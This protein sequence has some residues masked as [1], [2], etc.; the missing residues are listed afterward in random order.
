MIDIYNNRNKIRPI[1]ILK[2]EL[3]KRQLTIPIEEP[4]KS[5]IKE[6]SNKFTKIKLDRSQIRKIESKRI[7]DKDKIRKNNF[8][9]IQKNLLTINL[10]KDLRLK[11][12]K[13]KNEIKDKINRTEIDILNNKINFIEEQ[14]KDHDKKIKE[15]KDWRRD[16][17]EKHNIKISLIKLEKSERRD[18]EINK[19]EDKVKN[20]ENMLIKWKEQL[21][22]DNINEKRKYRNNELYSINLEGDKILNKFK[23]RIEILDE[24]KEKNNKE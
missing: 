2:F 21:K 13:Y 16:A 4:K 7:N 14:K 23:N 24:E 12:Q 5:K 19:I 3:G 15:K 20:K 9:K 17:L 8:E 18:I 11:N 6:D 22:E 1:E 10:K